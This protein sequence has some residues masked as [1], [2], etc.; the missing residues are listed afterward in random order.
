MTKIFSFSLIN[1]KFQSTKSKHG[2]VMMW[3]PKYH[4]RISGTR[5]C[6]RI[7]RFKIQID[8]LICLKNSWIYNVHQI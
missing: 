6:L 3:H 7:V 5:V 1:M 2:G 4:P 8:L